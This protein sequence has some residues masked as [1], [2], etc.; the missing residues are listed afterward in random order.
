MMANP[1]LRTSTLVIMS[2][3]DGENQTEIKD[4]LGISS[5]SSGTVVHIWIRPETE[6]N[7]SIDRFF[8]P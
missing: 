2:I 6:R 7:R 1:F 8:M 5:S 4:D 3:I